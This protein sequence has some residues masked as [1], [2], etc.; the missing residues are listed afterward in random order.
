MYQVLFLALKMPS[1]EANKDPALLKI[2]LNKN[3]LKAINVMK[4]IKMMPYYVLWASGEERTDDIQVRGGTE[5]SSG[6]K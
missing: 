2:T 4:T 1:E 5:F 6:H 3:F